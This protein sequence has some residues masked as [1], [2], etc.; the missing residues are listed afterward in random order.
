MHESRCRSRGTIFPSPN[1]L[2][3][4]ARS[5]SNPDRSTEGQKRSG[6]ES[7]PPTKNKVII[8][9]CTSWAVQK[10]ITILF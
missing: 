2:D 7:G 6:V 5:F 9:L 8:D 3:E 4:V 10:S 1:L